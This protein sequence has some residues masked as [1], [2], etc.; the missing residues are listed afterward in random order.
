M[1]PPQS[2]GPY[3]VIDELGSGGMA[4][5]YRAVNKYLRDSDTRDNASIQV[6]IKTPR[7]EILSE[8]LLAR[9]KQEVKSLYHLR[10]KLESDTIVT[11]DHYDEQDGTPYLVMRYLPGGTLADRL[12][13]KKHLSLAEALPIVERVARALDHAHDAGILHRD[14]KPGNILFDHAGNACLSDFGI[15]KIIQQADDAT[16][17]H[18]TPLGGIPGT[19]P[20]VSPEQMRGDPFDHRIDVYALG[21]VV[22]EMLVGGVPYKASTPV[23]QASMHVTEPIPSIRAMR[24]DLPEAVE[25]FIQ[26]A[27]AKEPDERYSS[28]GE[29]AAALRAVVK[30]S[31]GSTSD[32]GCGRFIATA[33]ILLIA[34]VGTG[35]YYFVGGGVAPP[36]PTS[37]PTLVE[38]VGIVAEP[39]ATPTQ[40]ATLTTA[41]SPTT[42]LTPTEPSTPT[43]TPTPTLTPTPVGVIVPENADRL[44]SIS[45][46]EYQL[47][48]DMALSADGRLVAVAASSMSGGI[49]LHETTSQTVI[50]KIETVSGPRAV[51]FS[52]DGQMLASG[53]GD[54]TVRL[55]RVAD[56]EPLAVL[57]KHNFPVLQ[58]AFSPDGQTLA[59]VS[60]DGTIR[61]WDISG[62]PRATME[63]SNSLI[64]RLAF[65]PD[66]QTL[67]SVA[68]RDVRLWRVSDGELLATLT[69]HLDRVH[70]VTFS[71]DG[72]MLASVAQ[73]KTV[74]LWAAA[75]GTP[76][77]TLIG[78]S[79]AV[80]RVAFSPDGQSLATASEDSTIRLWRVAIG[81]PIV[82]LIG[83]GDGVTDVTFSPDGRTLATA[84]YDRTVR[85]WRA[86]DGEPLATFGLEEPTWRISFSLDGQIMASSGSTVMRLW[87]IPAEGGPAP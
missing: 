29:L 65:S 17:P 11:I 85:L 20:Y 67:A 27:L 69:G 1:T 16:Q 78:H 54:G 22:F 68:N 8:Q 36:T 40:T 50:L 75:E 83:H 21:I 32:D 73:D 62:N 7:R 37:T 3:E 52:P 51:A 53:S 49:F 15:A 28:A 39:T 79:A 25:G 55:W 77:A 47:I 23:L 33:I 5:V 66:G 46:W 64:Q 34:V 61:L 58:V 56:G 81:E 72:Q 2:F 43:D 71:P 10:H 60:A 80:I 59:S 41:P 45:E 26:R 48:Y 13:K 30:L 31:P 4:V 19:P 70:R 38:T 76:L 14:V 35:L 9:F 44:V 87:G 63:S 6:A 24:S 74:R 57:G 12:E 18:H 42:S 82:T 84:S 86:I